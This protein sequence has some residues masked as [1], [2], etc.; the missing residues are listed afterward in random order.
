MTQP[1]DDADLFWPTTPLTDALSHTLDRMELNGQNRDRTL[2]TGI[3]GIDSQT[4]GL[5]KGE[6]IVIAGLRG[7]GT[8]ALAL[9]LTLHTAAV[10]KSP[11]LYVATRD[12]VV[13]LTERLLGTEAMVP[14]QQLESGRIRRDDWHS[15]GEAVQRL[16]TIPVFFYDHPV[17]SVDQ[18][19]VAATRLE[20]DRPLGLVII[21]RLPGVRGWQSGDGTGRQLIANALSTMARGLNIPVVVLARLR[22]KADQHPPPLTSD[23]VRSVMAMEQFHHFILVSQMNHDLSVS[24]SSPTA[25]LDI[26]DPIR[27]TEPVQVKMG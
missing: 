16:S 15:V 22:R 17:P 21:D 11:V 14:A 10:L 25:R 26:E 20:R 13:V 18:L 8:T 9:R 7:S 3:V 23:V 5:A 2:P 1:F 27:T 12:P 6:V 19:M 24:S 4:G